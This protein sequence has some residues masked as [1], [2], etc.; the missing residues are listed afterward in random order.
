M[1]SLQTIV[2]W[3]ELTYPNYD[4]DLNTQFDQTHPLYLELEKNYDLS[5]SDYFQ[6]GVMYFDTR[7]I[8]D[9]TKDQIISLVNKYPIT[10]TNEQGILNLYYYLQE[11]IQRVTIK[12]CSYTTYFYWKLTN[13]KIIITKTTDQNK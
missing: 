11:K 4:R 6:T 3:Q 9:Q 8:S 12:N 13:E 2:L 5:V 1:N 7:I 10:K